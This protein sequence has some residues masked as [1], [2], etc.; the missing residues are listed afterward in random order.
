VTRD[1]ARGLGMGIGL[2]LDDGANSRETPLYALR[3]LL[4]ERSMSL[5]DFARDMDTPEDYTRL[6]EMAR[7]RHLPSAAECEAILELHGVAEPVRRHG[8]AVAAVAL[9][10]SRSLD[11]LDPQLVNAAALLHDIGRLLE[12]AG[13]DGEHYGIDARHEDIGARALETCFPPT[14]T[15]PIR[16]RLLPNL[17]APFLLRPNHLRGNNPLDLL[18]L[19][20]YRNFG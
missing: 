8:R 6:A 18:Y 15:E 12:P 1:V 3:R 4:V 11:K 13:N 17:V 2:T 20:L 10:L 14:V 7:H 9:A 16:R 5:H 19:F